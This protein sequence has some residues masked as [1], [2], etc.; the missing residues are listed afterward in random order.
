MLE[1]SLVDVSS[2]A[3]RRL[4]PPDEALALGSAVPG[5]VRVDVIRIEIEKRYENMM[6]RCRRDRQTSILKCIA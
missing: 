5:S 1:R 3:L 6:R 4:G 2:R